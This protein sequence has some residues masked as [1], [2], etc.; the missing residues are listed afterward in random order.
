MDIGKV[1][2]S[3]HDLG[4]YRA[5]GSLNAHGSFSN[6]YWQ[7]HAIKKTTWLRAFRGVA[8]NYFVTT[9]FSPLE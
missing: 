2:F 8:S 4:I 9:D 1:Y 5:Y 6:K 7:R 3:R